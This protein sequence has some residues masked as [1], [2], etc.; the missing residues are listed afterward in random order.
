MRSPETPTMQCVHLCTGGS[1]LGWR[2]EQLGEMGGMGKEKTQG[3]V[4]P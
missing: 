2:N 4:R 3:G 1:G